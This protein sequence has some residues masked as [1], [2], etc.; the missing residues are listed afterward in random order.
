[1]VNIFGIDVSVWQG[2]FNFK[3]ASEEGVKFAIIRGAYNTSKDSRFEEY[4]KNAKAMGLSV[5]VYQYS[6]ATSVEKAIEEAKFLESNVLINKKFE[7]P[8]YFDIEDNVHKNLSANEISNISKGW[9]DY[10]EE[11]G[12]FVGVYS[13]KYFLESYINNEIRRRYAIWVA[14]WAEKCTYEGQYGMWQFGGETNL[15]R[16]N[17]IAGVVCD[18]NYMLVDYPSIIIE[19]GFN[20][21]GNSSDN[22]SGS[23]NENNSTSSTITYV[24][25]PGD[26]LSSIAVKYGTTYQE[27]ARING[28]SNPNLIYPGQVLKINSTKENEIYYT[29]KSGDTLSS[30]AAKYGTTYQEIARINGISNPNLIYPGQVIKIN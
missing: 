6:M 16:S 11:R 1:M 29:V 14:Q 7:L 20:G 3:Q 4:Y 27:I 18:Q 8:I 9:L 26:N 2:N 15:I 19:K 17:K 24:V 23:T 28:I 5:G 21:Y 30:I 22:S 10:L 13:N 25:Q 12:F